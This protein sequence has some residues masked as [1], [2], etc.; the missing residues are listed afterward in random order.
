[1]LTTE[2]EL[3]TYKSS[4]VEESCK[5]CPANSYTDQLGQTECEC[6][7]NFYRAQTDPVSY[8]CTR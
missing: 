4:V 8:K 1:M 7:V 6:N 5:K 3:N 2:C